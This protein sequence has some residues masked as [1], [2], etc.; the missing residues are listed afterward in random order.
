MQRLEESQY[1]NRLRADVERDTTGYDFV[2]EGTARKEASLRRLGLLLGSATSTVTD[3]STFRADLSDASN[4]GWN[5]GPLATAA[6][7]EDLRSSGRLGLIRSADLRARIISY[8]THAIGAE[9]RIEARSTEYPHI[10]YRLIP[11]AGG[12]EATGH[13][14]EER[15]VI[16]NLEELLSALRASGLSDHV[17]A[18]R[19]R[20]LFIRNAVGELR[21]EADSLLNQISA[22]A[23]QD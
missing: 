14:G 4:F 22:Y 11:Q 13:G 5:V 2:M 15:A 7:Y 21:S 3:T 10:A 16:G 18:E 12:L 9:R 8:Y 19:N 1:L 17:V 23:S 6:T 20:A